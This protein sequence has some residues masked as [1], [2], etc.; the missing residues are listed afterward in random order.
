MKLLLE[1]VYFMEKILLISLKPS[2]KRVEGVPW[3]DWFFYNSY[4]YIQISE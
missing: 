3:F 1:L 4:P 2:C